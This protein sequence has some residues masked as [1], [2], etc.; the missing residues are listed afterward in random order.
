MIPERGF[1]TFSPFSS[2][3]SSFL[4]SIFVLFLKRIYTYVLVIYV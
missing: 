3:S 2:N 1:I 4:K